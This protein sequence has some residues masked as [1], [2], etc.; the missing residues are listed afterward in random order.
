MNN[1]FNYD[2]FIFEKEKSIQNCLID[3]IIELYKIE[4]KK[5]TFCDYLIMYDDNFSKFKTYLLNEITCSLFLYI[6]EL[7]EKTKNLEL[8]QY[9]RDALSNASKNISEFKFSTKIFYNNEND[10]INTK[11]SI[12][13]YDKNYSTKIIILR[14]IWFMNDYDGV[15]IFCNNL[16]IIPK[17]GKL[18]IFPASWTFPY[19]EI[20]NK[21]SE[22][23]TISGF[24]YKTQ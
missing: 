6:I 19:E 4:Y 23:I 13:C 10:I 24:F 7:A 3:D 20:N 12:Q 17:K 8:K 14:F 9:F 15:I 21:S 22:I 2:N 18:I 11:R 16:K 5:D 1:S